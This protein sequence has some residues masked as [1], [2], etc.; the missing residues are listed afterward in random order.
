MFWLLSLVYLFQVV[1]RLE[2]HPKLSTI[3]YFTNNRDWELSMSF[4]VSIL[5]SRTDTAD[6]IDDKGAVTTPE[7]FILQ[8]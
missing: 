5:S 3:A 6:R 2:N 4:A 8:D 1:P 7:T